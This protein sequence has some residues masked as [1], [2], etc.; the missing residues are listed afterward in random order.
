MQVKC[1]VVFQL[2]LIQHEILANSS[3]TDKK[4]IAWGLGL[5][6][7][8]MVLFDILDIKYFWMDDTKFLEQ[9]KSGKITKFF[10][11]F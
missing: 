4:G 6:R 2:F 5:E 1:H 3:Q 9:F 8:A 7:L 10:E 11:V